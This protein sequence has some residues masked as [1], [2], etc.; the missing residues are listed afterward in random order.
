MYCEQ[1]ACITISTYSSRDS[2]LHNAV[3][4]LYNKIQSCILKRNHDSLIMEMQHRIFS[5]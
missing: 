5:K 3:P 4:E 2:D 1:A